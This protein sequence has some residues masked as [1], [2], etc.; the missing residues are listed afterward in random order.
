MSQSVN[1]GDP[2][3]QHNHGLEDLPLGRGP[4][5]LALYESGAGITFTPS[6]QYSFIISATGG[7][8]GSRAQIT[9]AP[10]GTADPDTATYITWETVYAAANTIA[11]TEMDVDII[12][13]DTNGA[14]IVPADAG[15]WDFYRLAFVGASSFLPNA[16]I[17]GANAMAFADGA[18][19]I[20]WLRGA[21]YL[22]ISSGSATPIVTLSDGLLH[23]V[24]LGELVSY[25]TSAGPIWAVDAGTLAEFTMGQRVRLGNPEG[26]DLLFTLEE[27]TV[28]YGNVNCVMGA[29]V[30]DGAGDVTVNQGSPSMSIGAQTASTGAV[31]INYANSSVIGSALDPQID[32]SICEGV[33]QPLMGATVGTMT[34]VGTGILGGYTAVQDAVAAGI[35]SPGVSFNQS[36][37]AAATSVA[38]V[39]HTAS[40]TLF[41]TEESRLLFS[42][43]FQVSAWT[44]IRF[45]TGLAQDVTSAP[46]L[47]DNPAFDYIG[48][49]FSTD[50]PDV[51]FQFVRRDAAQVVL[52][53]GVVP[54]DN[55]VY[56]WDMS[57]DPSTPFASVTVS[58]WHLYDSSAGVSVNTLLYQTTITANANIPVSGTL[59][60]GIEARAASARTILRRRIRLQQR[61]GA[62]MTA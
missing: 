53:T 1:S 30:F 2:V 12:V 60:S 11:L 26:S 29:D 51:N 59:F 54:Q 19:V 9:W 45:F 4:G 17:G 14:A 15:D 57:F 47:S 8:G 31:T 56:R 3:K 22:A 62:Y 38:Y 52:D 13:D 27:F 39:N 6:G 40:T 48:L 21:S 24:Y 49:Q 28:F 7:G 42:D 55:D 16:N 35:T 41:N 50:R 37:A 23:R 61:L 34:L 44:T 32:S 10:G 20:N 46:V 18:T 43:T 5:R 33:I 58:L 25:A 36:T